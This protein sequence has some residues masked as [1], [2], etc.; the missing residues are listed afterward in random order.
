R[1]QPG[2]DGQLL[3]EVATAWRRL[4]DLERAFSALETSDY[5]Q[6][7]L[8]EERRAAEG[9]S[10]IEETRRTLNAELMG[11]RHRLDG[12]SSVP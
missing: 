12:A 1:E 10:L 7:L 6:L 8:E 4:D 9:R 5:W 11:L 2:S 3:E